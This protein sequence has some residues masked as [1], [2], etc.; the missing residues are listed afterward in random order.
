MV[1]CSSKVEDLRSRQ[2]DI[3]VRNW[4]VQTTVTFT[5][6]FTSLPQA[7]HVRFIGAATLTVTLPLQSHA[8][9]LRLFV[10]CS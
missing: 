8:S 10:R 7:R 9:G 6:T 5:S 3:C 2:K 4:A 1:E